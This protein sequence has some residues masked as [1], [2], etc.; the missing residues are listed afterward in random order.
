MSRAE[1]WVLSAGFSPWKTINATYI[2]PESTIYDRSWVFAVETNLCCNECFESPDKK[3][4][5]LKRLF[6]LKK[7][8]FSSSSV[9]W[10]HCILVSRLVLEIV[11]SLKIKGLKIK[12][13]M[14]LK[15]SND[16]VKLRELY[17][18]NKVDWILF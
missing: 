4:L 1:K 16:F 7:N 6:Q 8:F 9:R 3:C 2:F 14:R 12:W 15:M 11:R 18:E 5:N 13:R 17:D 10:V